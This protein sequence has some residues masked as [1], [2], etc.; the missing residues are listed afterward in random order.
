MI[1]SP[2]FVKYSA[3]GVRSILTHPIPLIPLSFASILIGGIT[4]TTPPLSS[5]TLQ[6]WRSKSLSAEA[7]IAEP[8]EKSWANPMFMDALMSWFSATWGSKATP[9]PQSILPP[10]P[11]YPK[12]PP[13]ESWKASTTPSS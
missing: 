7:G 10:Q 1:I 12:D 5:T 4:S 3:Y 8:E 11:K 6:M 2:R 9:K 13:L